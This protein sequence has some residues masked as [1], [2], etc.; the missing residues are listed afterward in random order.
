MDKYIE[1]CNARETKVMQRKVIQKY[2]VIIYNTIKGA[3]KNINQI[4]L[5]PV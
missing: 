3:E 1:K 5:K 2:K 4:I